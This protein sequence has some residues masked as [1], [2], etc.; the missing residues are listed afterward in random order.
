MSVPF[1][2]FFFFPLFIMHGWLLYIFHLILYFC[3][4]LWYHF[5]SFFF[6]L[7][8]PF[9]TNDKKRIIQTFYLSLLKPEIE[10]KNLFL[11][12]EQNERGMHIQIVT[13]IFLLEKEVKNEIN[14]K[15]FRQTLI[16]NLY[17]DFGIKFCGISKYFVI[18]RVT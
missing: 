14:W 5:I 8:S 3:T 9:L 17:W 6:R 1:R 15:C 10:R 13:V 18:A 2:I 12:C 7:I 16:P 11:T 4:D